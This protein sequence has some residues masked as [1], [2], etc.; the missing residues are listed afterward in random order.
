MAIITKG[1]NKS[2]R[3]Y[4]R[5][6]VF[7]SG[8]DFTV[9]DVVD[10]ENSV[11]GGNGCVTVEA[12]AGAACTFKVNALNRRYPLLPAAKSLGFPVPDLQSETIWLNPNAPEYSLTA[13]QSIEFDDIPVANLEFT[14]ITDTVTVKVRS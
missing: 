6:V 8:V 7:A 10:V 1:V 11:G 2:A 14:A 3:I 13:G 12:G 9:N 4:G 5:G